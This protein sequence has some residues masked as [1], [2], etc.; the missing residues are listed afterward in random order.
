LNH[1]TTDVIRR[2]LEDAIAAEK[3][4]ETQ[5]LGF[6]EQGDDEE[7]R[8]LF[9][10]HAE[11]TRS[12]YGRLTRRL[13]QLGGSPSTGKNFLAHI[14]SLA[15]KSAQVAHSP[16]EKTA[17]NLIMAF[18]VEN[19]EC[20]MYEALAVTAD[21][22]G[23]S[24]TATLA[25]EIQAEERRTAEKVWHFLPSRSL[26]AYNL[27]TANEVDPSVETRAVDNRLI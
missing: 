17:Q 16:Q 20:A 25:R 26:I 18:S 3:S 4:F 27:M 22:C 11:E 1:L 24:E 15:P 14:F 21:S 6:S 23:D 12:Q 19:G 8:S 2:Y 13:E 5:L 7:V 9:A 10:A